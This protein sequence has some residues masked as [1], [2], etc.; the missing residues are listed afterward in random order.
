MKWDMIFKTK[1]TGGGLE[2]KD[3]KISQSSLLAKWKWRL[4][5]DEMTLWIDMLKVKY[6]KSASITQIF[7][8]IL[9]LFSLVEG[10]FCSRKETKKLSRLVLKFAKK[11]INSGQPSF[12]LA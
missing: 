6:G 4:A 12:F 7:F 10:Y 1:E 8:K 9:I 11:S 2:I 3:L 5:K